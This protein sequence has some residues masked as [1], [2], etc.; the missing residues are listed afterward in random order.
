VEISLGLEVSDIRHKNQRA[1][2]V[3]LSDGTE[4]EAR[5][6]ISTLDLK[7]TFSSLFAWNELP[8]AAATRVSTFRYA[9][10]T[11][12]LLLAL[13]AP[14]DLPNGS[15][16]VALDAPSVAR[17]YAAWR[18]GR[19]CE[20]L[21]MTL[22]LVSA[23]D[24]RLAPRGQAVLTATLGCIPR[25]L[26]DGAWSNKKRAD[27]RDQALAQIEIALPG[28]RA[29]VLAAELIVPPDIEEALGV[30]EGDLDGGEVAPDQMF[31]QRGFL[32]CRGGRTPIAG[33]YLGGRSA[34]A[35]TFGSCAAGFAAAR[36]VMTDI[37]AGRPK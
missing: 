24:P 9:P 16:I 31:A 8:Q 27:L 37:S 12:R 6:V 5:T 28:T 21:P 18:A 32:E 15:A 33:L 26:F 17:G 30:T 25:H 11:A 35:G 29:G 2:G 34:P 22:R 7:R 1:T 3:R 20:Q 19:V 36:A 4:I 23:A 10:A 14:P 13:H